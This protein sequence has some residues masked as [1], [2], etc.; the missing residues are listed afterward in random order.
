[1]FTRSGR[2]ALG[3]RGG[4]GRGP[5]RL[6]GLDVEAEV[7]AHGAWHRRLR[8][9]I[10]GESRE[11]LDVG[12]VSSP[13]GCALGQWLAGAGRQSSGERPA[14]AA[15]GQAHQAFHTEA[16]AVLAHVQAGERLKAQRRL[17]TT[18]AQRS[19]ELVAALDELCRSPEPAGSPTA[20]A[21]VWDDFTG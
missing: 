6:A 14:F 20:P 16:G 5:G 7:L 3:D 19:A 4:I 15:L 9:T 21:L 8:D 17:L 13:E 18:F 11:P 1:M 12:T 10:Q 2:A